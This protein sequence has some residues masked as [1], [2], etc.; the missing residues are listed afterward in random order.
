MTRAPKSSVRVGSTVLFFFLEFVCLFLIVEFNR[1]KSQTFWHS[2]GLVTGTLMEGV[3]F[4]QN[5]IGQQDKMKQIQAENAEL[6]SKLINLQ[7]SAATLPDP[8][9]PDTLAQRYHLIPGR[10]INK[11]IIGSN[12]NFT[13]DIGGKDGVKPHMGVISAHGIVG[14]VVDTSRYFS[15]VMTILHS[16]ARIDAR[17]RSNKFHGSL[18]WDGDETDYLML[19]AI[20]KHVRVELGDTVETSGYTDLFPPDILIGKVDS[21]KPIAGEST[22]FIRVKLFEDIARS[23]YVYVVENLF[24]PPDSLNAKD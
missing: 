7:L 19:K 12:N 9:T 11:N 15:K 14:I 6:K 4:F 17:L 5:M 10:V 24:T 3:Q 13:I 8:P 22:R 18:V 23:Q 21:L 20:P 2:A 1:G 16:Q